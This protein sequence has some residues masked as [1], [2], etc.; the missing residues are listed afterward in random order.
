MDT[1]DHTPVA[2][3]NCFSDRGLR[4]DAE[5]IGQDASGD[6]PNCGAN[7]FKKLPAAGVGALAHRFFVWGSMWRARFGAA[8]LIQFNEHQ[9]TSIEVAPWLSADIKLIERLLGIG[10]FHYGSRLWM[11]GEIEPLKALQQSKK[12]K[13]VIDRILT[14]YPERILVQTDLFY[15]V[16]V[17]PNNPSDPSQYDSPPPQSAGRGR[18][19]SSGQ[20][21]LYGSSDLEVCVHECR[22]AAED[23][24][25]AATL[26]P[27]RPLRLLDL[28]VLLKEKDV[29]EFES[30]DMSVHM[31]FL[32]GRHAYKI[33]RAIADAARG[34]GFDGLV[35]PSYFSL[36]RIGQMPFQTTYGI[37]HRRIPQYQDYEQAKAIQNLALF[38]R[39]IA[40]GVVSVDCINRLIL[41]R[42]GYEFHFGPTG[43]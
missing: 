37:S 24:L 18:L 6:C 31:L 9:S 29:T 4:L 28:S 11:I 12:R 8:P 15:R 20:P 7:G 32:A 5:R 21:V 38:G 42:V 17:S 10:F 30:L 3:A 16:R 23:D 43:A 34:A 26:S 27:T 39:P 14:E 33:T 13:S 35:Y 19:D 40:T 25:F 41:S 22:V 2:C 1:P 36:L